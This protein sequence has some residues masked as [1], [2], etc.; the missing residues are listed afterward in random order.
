M[1][2]IYLQCA[3]S[4]HRIDSSEKTVKNI[5]ATCRLVMNILDFAMIIWGAVVVFAA[6]AT[7]TDDFDKYNADMDGFNYCKSP[8]MIF[9]FTILLIKWVS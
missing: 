4:D 7:W 6:W 3:M 1:A 9:A 8:P 2:K 5:N